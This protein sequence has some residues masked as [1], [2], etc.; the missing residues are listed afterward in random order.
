MIGIE[1]IDLFRPVRQDL[2]EFSPQQERRQA[3]R[4]ALEKTLARDTGRDRHRRVVHNQA[5]GELD[6]DDFSVPVK[7]PRERQAGLRIPEEKRFVVNEIMGRSWLAMPLNICRS[8]NRQDA[9]L[10]QLAYDKG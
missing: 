7:L 8:G 3:D 2:N 1:R 10:Q 9:G 4:E 5:A 6:L